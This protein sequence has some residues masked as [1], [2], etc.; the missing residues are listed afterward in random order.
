MSSRGQDA[1][2]IRRVANLDELRDTFEVIGQQFSPP[3]GRDDS[4]IDRLVRDFPSDRP[5][6]LVVEHDG[7]IIGGAL[8]FGSTLRIIGIEEWARGRGLG[9]RLL[10]TFEVA[11]MRHGVQEISLGAE[12]ARGFYQRQGYRGKSS[13]HKQLALPGAVRDLRLRKLERTIGDLDVG[14][15][16]PLSD[17]G[18]VPSLL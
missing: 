17:D 3:I 18:R 2:T 12:D 13:M 5:L 15:P 8:G 1:L 16:V 4:R 11:A 9:R 7:R 6:M 10:Q 14:A